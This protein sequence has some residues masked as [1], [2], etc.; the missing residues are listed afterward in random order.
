MDFGDP[1]TPRGGQKIV[2]N[3][4]TQGIVGSLVV[5]GVVGYTSS[6]LNVGCFNPGVGFIKFF[7]IIE[8]LGRFLFIPVVFDPDLHDVLFGINELGEFV[9]FD[10]DI[11]VKTPTIELKGQYRY[12]FKLTIYNEWKNIFQSMPLSIVLLSLILILRGVVQL[13]MKLANSKVHTRQT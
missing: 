9:D 1:F 8:I 4:V 2:N 5:A 11:L 13:V 6:I 3:G 7:Q 10:H 12:W